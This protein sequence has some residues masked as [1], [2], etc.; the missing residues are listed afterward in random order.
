MELR[1]EAIKAQYEAALSLISGF[2]H[3]PRLAKA[4]APV[5]TEERSP[6]IGARPRFR[7]TIPGM[8]ARSTARPGGVR[9]Y[10]RVE[11]LGD[12]LLSPLQASALHALRRG[13][14]IA[15]ALGEAFAA[16]S[17]LAELKKANLEGRLPEARRAEFTDLLAGE[18]LAVLY[19]FANA[20]AF[21]L[22][23]HLGPTTVE[24]GEVEEVLT[25]NA[26]L[27][28]QGALWELDQD[29]ALF[30][31]DEPRLIA[32]L[33]AW[34]WVQERGA[35]KA[36]IDPARVAVAGDRAGGGVLAAALGFAGAGRQEGEQGGVFEEAGPEV[37]AL[38]FGDDEFHVAAERGVAGLKESRVG[39]EGNQGVAVAVNREE[40]DAGGGEGGGQLRLLQGQRFQPALRGITGRHRF[41]G[42]FIPQLIETEIDPG[43]QAGRRLQRLGVITEQAGHFRSAF[44]VAFGIGAEE[45]AGFRNG[46]AFANDVVIADHQT[47][48]FTLVLE[49]GGILAYRGKL[50]DAVVLADDGRALEDHV[51]TDHRT[52]ADFHTCADDRPRADLDAVSQNGRRIDDCA[53][54]NQTHS[55]RSAQMISAEQTSLPSTLA[56]HWNFQM[57]RLLLR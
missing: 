35:A 50:V 31:S 11:A 10:E 53:R 32:T 46:D 21:L 49:V 37:V 52:L 47:G 20:T 27:A 41:V 9:L 39:V 30:A 57:L 4:L 40:R 54:V 38:A 29:I 8:A 16:Q 34:A 33:A 18:A 56:L 14:A 28:L 7:S 23:P 6:G 51:G 17:G 12:G 42:I 24:I 45:L 22:A 13:V 1:E 26:P 48:R 15:L 25:D 19:T 2:D 43:Q 44:Q 36:G 3:A 55:L 5:A